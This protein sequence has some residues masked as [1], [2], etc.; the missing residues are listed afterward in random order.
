MGKVRYSTTDVVHPRLHFALE[1][2]RPIFQLFDSRELFMDFDS[3]R[4]Q[5]R[6][7]CR[8]PLSLRLL[9]FRLDLA[10]DLI[11]RLE[12][13]VAILAM[14]ALFDLGLSRS[15]AGRLGLA[16]VCCASCPPFPILHSRIMTIMERRSEE[17]C[18]KSRAEYKVCGFEYCGRGKG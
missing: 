8:R 14:S 17:Y 11:N 9:W 18:I 12:K 2:I 10:D 1:S 3:L 7:S 15:D 5:P 6:T 4:L 13:A 16:S